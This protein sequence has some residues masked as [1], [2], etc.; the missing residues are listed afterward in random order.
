MAV[1]VAFESPQTGEVRQVKVGFSWA[2]FFF[3]GV[4]GI[5]LFRRKLIAW[6][7]VMLAY[8]I[9]AVLLLIGSRKTDSGAS[10][11]MNVV[12]WFA[13]A[14][15]G[16]KGN[17]ITAKNYLASGWRF[18]EPGSDLTRYAKMKWHIFDQTVSDPSA[19]SMRTEPHW[20]RQS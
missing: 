20:D 8:N 7:W 11:I 16:F 19:N 9:A 5:P 3:S 13:L 15:L 12:I 14:Y 18:V 6:G 4:F 2:L 10:L 17:E 1:S